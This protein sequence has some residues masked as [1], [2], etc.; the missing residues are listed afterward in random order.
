MK[1]YTVEAYGKYYLIEVATDGRFVLPD[2]VRAMQSLGTALKPAYEPVM[3]ARKPLIGTVA[4]NVLR[5][6]TGAINVDAG[7]VACEPITT[8]NGTALGRISDDSW[9]ATKL[10]GTEFNSHP[11]GR[12]PANFIHDGSD[13]VVALFPESV[14]T[15]GAGEAS[16][17]FTSAKGIY[18][19]FA[20]MQRANAGGLGDSG[21]AARFFYCAKAS[22]DDRGEGNTHPT[23]KPIDLMMYLVKLVTPEGATVIEPYCGSGTTAA[24]CYRLH[25][26]CIA[27]EREPEYF[28]MAI[29]RMKREQG[30]TPLFVA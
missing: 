5:Y 24:A 27:I 15:G 23:V 7:R 21:S 16:A 26:K 22:G 25:R 6:G 13:E 20:P 28:R 30:K 9:D 8:T 17:N 2:E 12:F 1:T 3:V 19:T 29:E 10:K 11:A 4:A 14:S 18:G